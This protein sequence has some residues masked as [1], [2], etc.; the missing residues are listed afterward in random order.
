MEEGEDEDE[1]TST[2]LPEMGVEL[3]IKLEAGGAPVSHLVFCN[4][5]RIAGERAHQGNKSDGKLHRAE[6]GRLKGGSW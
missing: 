6:D 3:D 5:N 4:R 2:L 1:W